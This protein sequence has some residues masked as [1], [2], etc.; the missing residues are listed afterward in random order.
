MVVLKRILVAT[1]FSEASQVALDYGR[2][3]ARS[4]GGAL[5]LLHVSD[6]VRWR[7]SLDMSPVL[8]TSVQDDL[9]AT[10]RVRLEALL[11]DD[12]RQL[13][14]ST[15]VRTSPAVAEAI[16]DYARDQRIDL[17]VIGT[18]GRGVMSHFLMG[19]VAERVVRTAPCP[20][21][22]VRH[23]QRD[24]IKPDALTAIHQA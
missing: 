12:D 20:V 8:L 11:T 6:D 5:H 10:S 24:F 4:Y 18:H 13:D 1:D 14:V 21:L 7:Y 3:L 16:V 19:S 2:D 15:E 17:I 23:Q 22:T 9:E